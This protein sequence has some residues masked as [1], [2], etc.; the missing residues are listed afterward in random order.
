[1]E[2]FGGHFEAAWTARFAAKIGIA[3][4]D[5]KDRDQ[6]FSLLTIM[7]DQA[8]DFTLTFRHLGA[9][10]ESGSGEDAFL[11]RFEEPEAAR[12]WLDGWRSHLRERGAEAEGARATMRRA[13]PVFIPRNHR[14]EEV[15]QAGRGG[16]F[17]P[18]QR[19]HEILQRPFEE[20]PIHANYEAAPEEHEVVQATF[21]GT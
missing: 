15:I 3:Q 14:V 8:A 9:A 10:L 2:G 11:G 1:L 13:N 7:R 17:G 4:G 21:C 20:Q 12:R 18:F 16:D 19:L 5:V 6:V